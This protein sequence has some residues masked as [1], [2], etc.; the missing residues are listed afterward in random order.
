MSKIKITRDRGYADK[1][2]LYKVICNGECIGKIRDGETK[3]FESAAGNK[4]IYMKID[5]CR[6]N[7]MTVDVPEEGTVSLLCGS[8]LQGMT[9]LP[10]LIIVIFLPHKYLWLRGEKDS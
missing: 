4:E 8:N 2:R 5:W 7:K 1:G 9:G 10:G 6:S 3:E